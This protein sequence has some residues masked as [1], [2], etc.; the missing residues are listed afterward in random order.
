MKKIALFLSFI[1][2]FSF[3]LMATAA[4]N[5]TVQQTPATNQSA[6]NVSESDLNKFANAHKE[7]MQIQQKYQQQIQTNQDQ[8]AAVQLQQKAYMEMSKA[9]EN[10]GLTTQQY[11]QIAQQ[12]QQSPQLQKKLQ[13]MQ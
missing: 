7:V 4:T 11:S 9:V 12:I 3:S 2:G 6:S 8:K 5:N 1:T 10:N 13:N